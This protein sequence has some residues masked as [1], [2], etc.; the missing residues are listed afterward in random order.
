MNTITQLQEQ[1]EK[2]FTE[3]ELPTQNH[4]N[5]FA[6]NLAVDWKKVFAE[7]QKAEAE[8]IA[9][10]RVKICK[11]SE[12]DEE[13][14]QKY[15]QKLVS[16]SENKL[17]ALHYTTNPDATV[18]IIPKNTKIENQ[19]IINLKTSKAVAAESIIIVAEEG[20]EA[21][22]IEKNISEQE[23]HYQSHIVQIYAEPR[24]TITYCTLY[25]NHANTYSFN[26]K[27]AEV[28]QDA[29]IKC[30]DLILGNGFTQIQLRSHLRETGAATQQYQVMVGS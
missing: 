13:F 27:R 2:K 19:I 3:L 16:S 6:L 26:I 11:L 23:T 5:G 9:D 12:L 7:I 10:E 29:K 20:A 17:L 24:A 1:A 28:L 21:T 15:A 25:D 30:F 18:I 8:V 14:I 4:G 22:I